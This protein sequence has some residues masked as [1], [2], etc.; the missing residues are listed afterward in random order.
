MGDS[1]T[2]YSIILDCIYNCIMSK[3]ND[4][5]KGGFV[6]C[7]VKGVTWKILLITVVDI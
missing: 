1:T 7:E 5:H 2:C 3:L 4:K 6:T